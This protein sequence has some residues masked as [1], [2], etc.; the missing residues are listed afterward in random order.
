MARLDRLSAILTMLRS[1]RV[2][3]AEKIAERF[4]I[5]VR[6]VYRDI[7]SLEESGVPIGSEA[8]VGYF[9]ADGYHLPPVSLTSEE[10]RALLIGDKLM[11][12]FSDKETRRNYGLAVDK[13]KAVLKASEKESLEDIEGRMRIIT[14]SKERDNVFLSEI[15]GALAESRRLGIEYYARYRDETRERKVDPIGLCHYGDEWHMIAFCHK[16]S[17]YR[18]FRTDRIRSLKVLEE[19]FKPSKLLSLDEYWEKYGEGHDTF[20][21]EVLFG[22]EAKAWLS[23][24]KHRMGMVSES[25]EQEGVRIKFRTPDYK[26]LAYW[27]LS[28]GKH[29][30]EIKPEE[31]KQEYNNILGCLADRFLQK[32][33]R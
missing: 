12:R 28:F 27:L 3:T 7:R 15:Q 16:R 21:A 6:T 13:V 32:V 18:D 2:L 8:G 31:M 25:E 26:G 10:A 1:K 22:L 9:L 23:S 30:L 11:E 24:Q 29:V 17:D 4:D 33:E 5:S 20:P 19:S 14:Y